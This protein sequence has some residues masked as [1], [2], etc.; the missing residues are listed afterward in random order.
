MTAP[1][2]V[3]CLPS[4][5]FLLLLPSSFSSLS[6]LPPAFHFLVIHHPCSFNFCSA[7]LLSFFFFFFVSLFFCL[8]TKV[9]VGYF[10]QPFE[11]N[12]DIVVGLNNSLP[13]LVGKLSHQPKRLCAQKLCADCCDLSFSLLKKKLLAHQQSQSHDK[14]S[15]SVFLFE[16]QLM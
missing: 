2:Y 8:F 9:K 11:C 15:L 5:R 14:Y 4:I 10:T 1:R 12:R 3:T 7:S 13:T 16:S 6:C